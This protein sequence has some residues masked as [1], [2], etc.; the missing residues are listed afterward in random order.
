MQT[1]PSQAIH[2]PYSLV[3]LVRIRFTRR[4][5]TSEAAGKIPT[6]HSGQLRSHANQTLCHASARGI[7]VAEAVLQ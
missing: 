2:M 5:R 6:T 4:D 1:N 7:V 3:D